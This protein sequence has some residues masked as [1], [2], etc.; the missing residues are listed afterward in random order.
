MTNKQF[1]CFLLLSFCLNSC[2][3]KEHQGILISNIIVVSGQNKNILKNQNVVI[4][5]GKIK[6]IGTGDLSRKFPKDSIIDGTGKYLTP[7]LIDGHVHLFQIPGMNPNI[8]KKNPQIRDAFWEQMPKSYLYYG[9]TTL[10]ELGPNYAVEKVSASPVHPDI[11]HCDNPLTLANGYGMTF[12]EGEERYEDHPN[13]L[14]D[15]R[16]KNDIPQKYTPLDHT[17]KAVV[18]RVAENEGSLIKVHYE[19]GFGGIFNWP[20]PTEKMIREVVKEAGTYN[21]PVVLHANSLKGYRFGLKT[22]VDI[23]AHGLWHWGGYDNSQTMPAEIMA[24]LDS[25]IAAGKK[26][27]PTIQVIYSERSALERD[28]LA[29]DELK[30][31]VPKLLLDW[32]HTPQA[33]W[34][35][36]ELNQLYDGNAALIS[37]KFSIPINEDETNK[38]QVITIYKKQIDATVQYLARNGAKILF[39]SDTPSSPSMTNPIGYNGHLEILNLYHN[40]LSLKKL[41]EALTL[42]NS[43]AFNLKDIGTIEINKKANLLILDKNPLETIEAYNSIET[44]ILNGKVYER[45]VFKAK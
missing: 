23:L 31:T 1:L 11:Y 39:G 10:I 22:N 20:T 21:L 41:F 44:V 4:E 40:G 32:Y 18:K 2:N 43:E 9:F 15:E 30:N 3:N 14:Y 7:G 25:L 16:Q 8:A 5:N 24:V 42:N 37:A 34:Y 26:F 38:L 45:S 17:P 6:Y 12:D 28:F 19:D 35:F 27:M 13:F 33:A 29:N 36:E